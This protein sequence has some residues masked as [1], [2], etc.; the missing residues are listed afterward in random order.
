MRHIHHCWP[1]CLPECMFLCLAFPSLTLG[2]LF[3][4]TDGL[5]D[6]M[7]RIKIHQEILLQPDIFDRHLHPVV[8]IC[9]KAL[10]VSTVHLVYPAIF[11]SLR[12]IHTNHQNKSRHSSTQNKNNKQIP[13]WRSNKQESVTSISVSHTP[14]Q[15][16]KSCV[17][18]DH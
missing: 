2:H 1:P 18:M 4:K 16:Q 15:S 14:E 10:L 5:K 11:I 6:E 13:V 12:K 3:E 9:L 7:A 17:Y 8:D